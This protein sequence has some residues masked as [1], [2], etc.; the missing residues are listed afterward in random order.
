MMMMEKWFKT[1][2]IIKKNAMFS[3]KKDIVRLK[4]GK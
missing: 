3:Q 1:E 4:T 2:N